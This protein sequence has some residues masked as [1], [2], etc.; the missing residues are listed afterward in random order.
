[1]LTWFKSKKKSK[2]KVT[3]AV[4]VIPM[5]P[6]NYHPKIIL[7]WAKAVDGNVEI[8]TW[9]TDNGFQELTIA[10]SAIRLKDEARTWLMQNGY[11]HLMAMINAAEGNTKAAKWLEINKMDLLFH[12]SQAV[13]DNQKSWAWLKHNATQDLFILAQSIKIVKDKIEERH[14]DIH[15][16]G[17]D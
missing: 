17:G 3:E 12:I 14:N 5:K 13:E 6:M 7:A 16:F 15:S 11:P 2:E 10:C 4:E 1:M 8:A 9:L